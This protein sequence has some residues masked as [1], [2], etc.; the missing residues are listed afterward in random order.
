MALEGILVVGILLCLSFALITSFER[1]KREKKEA[2]LSLAQTNAG[3]IY[4]LVNHLFLAFL[5]DNEE[6]G[7]LRTGQMVPILP[8]MYHG[9]ALLTMGVN[10]IGR[11]NDIEYV[12]L[13]R[14]FD[15]LIT[16]PRKEE[17]GE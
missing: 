17:K 9:D 11:I 3:D 8:D 14:D 6:V 7:K 5:R 13:N 12:F 15:K 2:K 16:F 4:D 10:K 1:R